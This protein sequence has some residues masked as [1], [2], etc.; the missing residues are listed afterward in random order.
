MAELSSMASTAVLPL[1]SAL[2]GGVGPEEPLQV[3]VRRD[4]RRGALWPQQQL[5]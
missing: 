3:A 2:G 5:L 4:A 1:P